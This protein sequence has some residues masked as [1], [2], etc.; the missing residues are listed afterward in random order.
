M[1]WD[2]YDRHLSDADTMSLCNRISTIVDAKPEAEYPANM[3]AVV[4]LK[5]SKGDYESFVIVPKGEPSNFVSA[6]E[7][8]AKFMGLVQPYLE[9][10]QRE[11]LLAGLLTLDGIDDIASLMAITRAAGQPAEEAA[12]A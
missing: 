1:G 2:H 12:Q 11:S 4:R 5:T 3:S 8:R 10:A 9:S 7:V 6:E